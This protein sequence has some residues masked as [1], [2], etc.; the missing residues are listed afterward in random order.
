[1][2]REINELKPFFKD[3]YFVI[4]QEGMAFTYFFSLLT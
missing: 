4:G 1:M 2:E 3:T